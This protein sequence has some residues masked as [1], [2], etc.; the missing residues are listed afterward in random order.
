MPVLLTKSLIEA[1]LKQSPEVLNQ[2]ITDL[3]FVPVPVSEK[4]PQ[5]L[6]LDFGDD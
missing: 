5:Q 4:N 1:W 2:A 3:Q 6:R